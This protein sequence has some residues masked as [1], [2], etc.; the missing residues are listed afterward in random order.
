N[1]NE[2]LDWWLLDAGPY[3][4]AVQRF[5]A[6]LNQL[7]VAEPGLWRSDFDLNGFSWIDC[8]DHEGSVL[9]FLRQ[10]SERR[11]EVVVIAN[12]TPVPR[13]GY[14]VGLPRAGKWR[15]AINSDAGIY[16]GSNVGNLGG[17]ISQPSKWHN[18]AHS[19]EFTLPPL[20]IMAFKPDQ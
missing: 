15:E 10:D 12:L 11:N 20:S 5:V 1:A 8:S 6:D 7:Y 16:G 17:V 9:S 18:Q 14:R 3:H 4:R 13:Y 2:Q 19:A